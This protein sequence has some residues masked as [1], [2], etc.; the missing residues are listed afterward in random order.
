ML[1]IHS[2]F[3]YEAS[4]NWYRDETK[5]VNCALSSMKENN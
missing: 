2:L 5:D 4:S 3:N 1:A